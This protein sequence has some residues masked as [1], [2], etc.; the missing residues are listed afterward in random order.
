V[1]GQNSTVT[2]AA[3]AGQA[4]TV[5]LT[6][7]SYPLARVSVVNPDGSTLVSARYFGT[8]GLTFS[9]TAASAGAYAIVVDPQQAYTGAVTATVTSP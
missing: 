6:G 3:V 5:K 2:F 1:P 8:A 4:F 7:S 9:A